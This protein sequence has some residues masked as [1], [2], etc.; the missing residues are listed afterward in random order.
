MAGM[1]RPAAAQFSFYLSLPTLGAAS[2]YSL[3][4]ARHILGANDIAALAVGFVASFI[5]A[6]IVVR[7]FITF[8]QRHDFRPFGIYRIVAGIVVLM[9]V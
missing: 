9:L 8:V 4:K 5:S 1:G 3:W 6:L 7:L 2:L